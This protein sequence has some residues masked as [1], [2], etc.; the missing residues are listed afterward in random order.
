MGASTTST[1][2]GVVPTTRLPVAI[3]C[4]PHLP[5]PRPLHWD[6]PSTAGVTRRLD[7]P[8][9]PFRRLGSTTMG[10]LGAMGNAFGTKTT[11][12]ICKTFPWRPSSVATREP[13]MLTVATTRTI[14]PKTETASSVLPAAIAWTTAIHPTARGIAL[15]RTENVCPNRSNEM[16]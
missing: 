7:A 8:I 14:R 2:W 1:V 16:E 12:W 6:R 13:P 4:H 15:K 5:V 3:A 10:C 9:V 11:I